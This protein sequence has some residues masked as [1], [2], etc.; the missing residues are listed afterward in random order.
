MSWPPFGIEQHT[1]LLSYL[2][3]KLKIKK[4]ACISSS[5][6]LHEQQRHVFCGQFILEL[7][8]KNSGVGFLN[9]YWNTLRCGSTPSHSKTFSTTRQA[10]W[11]NN[12]GGTS[13]HV[14]LNRQKIL[15]GVEKHSHF[16]GWN[17]FD[18]PMMTYQQLY[19]TRGTERSLI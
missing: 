4:T 8:G 5:T 11:L 19:Y 6:C 1:Q 14:W 15:R 7:W 12:K 10:F 9:K 17:G 2:I 16:L 18:V 13:Y 3:N